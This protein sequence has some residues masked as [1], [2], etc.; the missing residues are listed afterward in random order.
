VAANLTAARV[1]LG[2]QDVASDLTKWAEHTWA[3]IDSVFSKSSGE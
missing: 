3:K 2:A 1:E